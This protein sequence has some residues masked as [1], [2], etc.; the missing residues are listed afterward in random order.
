MTKDREILPKWAVLALFIAVPLLIV[1]LVFLSGIVRAIKTQPATFD[2]PPSHLSDSIF[3][4]QNTEYIPDSAY[5]NHYTFRQLPYQIDLP[6][7]EQARVGNGLFVRL[8]SHLCLYVSEAKEE[9]LGGMI[10]T[11]IPRAYFSSLKE[12]ET[13]ARAVTSESGYLNGYPLTYTYL[14]VECVTDT[15]TRGV[16]HIIAYLMT[17]ETTGRIMVISAVTD[18]PSADGLVYMQQLCEKELTLL[19]KTA[20][21]PAAP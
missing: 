7:G 17:E 11:E 4:S 3:V 6:D 20:V 14:T 21:A 16:V 8:Q 12:E 10:K 1:C 2:A 9:D 15:G 5:P 18:R 19:A 13:I